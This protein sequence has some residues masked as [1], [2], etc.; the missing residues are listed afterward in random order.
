VTHATHVAPSESDAVPRPSVAPPE[1]ATTT[2]KRTEA[3]EALL[4]S[5]MRA[6]RFEHDAQR[7]G[8]LA[9]TYLA[10]YPEDDLVEEAMAIAIEAHEQLDDG[11]AH[12][13]ASRYL[14]RFPN[15]RFRATALH[16]F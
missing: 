9:G 3:P 10:R 12:A 11:R 8:E 15:G 14:M 13:L 16:A 6:L 1:A 5:A 4:Q 7:A 2:N